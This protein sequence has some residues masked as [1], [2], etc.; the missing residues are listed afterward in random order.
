MATR[1]WISEITFSD[2]TTLRFE[3][4]DIV[5]FVGPNNAG[6]SAS[7]KESATLLRVKTNKGKV[8]KDIV[9]EKEGD[10]AEFLENL[11][12]QSTKHFGGNP[13]PH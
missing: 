1:I 6:K 10:E 12:A 7:L 3:K 5:V 11:L 9:I 8:L 4:D 2:E 13:H